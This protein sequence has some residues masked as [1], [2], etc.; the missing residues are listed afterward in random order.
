[1]IL[2]ISNPS[3][4]EPNAILNN[5]EITKKFKYAPQGGIRWT[6]RTYA[7]ILVSNHAKP[8][9]DRW[10]GNVFHYTGM[11]RVGNQTLT[12]QNRTVTESGSFT[13]SPY[14]VVG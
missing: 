13:Y 10:E 14:R 5:N 9:Y 1:M 11:G 6:H 4:L 3:Q 2:L 12:T 7:L 8:L